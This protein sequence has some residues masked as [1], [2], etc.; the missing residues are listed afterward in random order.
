[1]EI[2]AT[3]IAPREFNYTKDNTNQQIAQRVAEKDD[4]TQKSPQFLE[5]RPV[6]Q[7]GAYKQGRIDIYA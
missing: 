7:A 2:G 3:N 4:D 1:M 5:P 6:E